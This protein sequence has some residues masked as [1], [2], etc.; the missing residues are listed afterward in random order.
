MKAAIARSRFPRR[1]TSAEHR[2][3]AFAADE[4][5]RRHPATEP[6]V[7]LADVQRD[8]R[9]VVRHHEDDQDVGDLGER[10]K[11]RIQ[12]SDEEEPWRAE[13]QRER[14]KQAST[15]LPIE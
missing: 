3:A 1:E 10:E 5:S 7:T 2:L 12:E 14:S 6:S 15:N 4:Y 9:L 8:K 13:R 11:R